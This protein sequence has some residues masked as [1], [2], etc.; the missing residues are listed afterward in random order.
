MEPKRNGCM[1]GKWNMCARRAKVG[2]VANVEAVND[3]KEP[4]QEYQ[5][6]GVNAWSRYVDEQ[7]LTPHTFHSLR[8]PHYVLHGY[9][10]PAVWIRT[11]APVQD[12]AKSF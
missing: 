1:H 12:G 10:E 8:I 4:K 3:E 5:M 2:L 9:P 6:R 11:P 7:P